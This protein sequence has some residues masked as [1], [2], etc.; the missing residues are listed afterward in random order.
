MIFSPTPNL[1]YRQVVGDQLKDPVI[2]ERNYLLRKYK[3]MIFSQ[4]PNLL[5]RQ[6]VG[7]QLKNSLDLESISFI[8]DNYRLKELSSGLEIKDHFGKAWELWY[9]ASNGKLFV[10]FLQEIVSE[11]PADYVDHIDKL[12]EFCKEFDVAGTRI[13][14]LA[15][16][17][18]SRENIQEY[19][20]NQLPGVFV[21]DLNFSEWNTVNYF[22]NRNFDNLTYQSTLE[23]KRFSMFSRH[24]KPWRHL[25]IGKL[26]QENLLD[27]FYFSFFNMDPYKIVGGQQYTYD[28]SFIIEQLNQI[29]HEFSK[30][31]ASTHFYQNLPFRLPT[32]SDDLF[33]IHST[34]ATDDAFASSKIHITIETLFPYKE[35]DWH[36]T[37]KTYKPIAYKKP[38]L[39]FSSHLFL[40]NL[41]KTGYATFHPYIDETY[42]TTEDPKERLA[43]IVAEIKRLCRLEEKEFQNVIQ[44]CHE[45]VEWNFNRLLKRDQFYYYGTYTDPAMEWAIG[46]K[47]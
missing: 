21:A 24:Y 40:K 2:L 22:K 27:N 42:D 4:T 34:S 31:L 16:N 15:A 28:D 43:A 36:P 29:D 30:E 47:R 38:F 18:Q 45:R 14:I 9:S 26:F 35:Y 6:V 10:T 20:I 7:G 17:F 39:T 13:V 44:N 46:Y 37:E 1:L 11:G 19:L 8:I 41:R 32:V 25:F 3:Q 5:Y 23:T 12:V 33:Q